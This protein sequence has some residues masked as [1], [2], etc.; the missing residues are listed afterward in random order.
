M[1]ASRLPYVLVA[2]IEVAVAALQTESGELL[3]KIKTMGN[4]KYGVSKDP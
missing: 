2:D 4:E 1:P 3:T